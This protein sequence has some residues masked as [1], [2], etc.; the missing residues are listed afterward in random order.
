[1]FQ[2]IQRPKLADTAALYANKE[3]PSSPEDIYVTKTKITAA[4]KNSWD[5]KD[6]RNINTNQTVKILKK[7]RTNTDEQIQR[8]ASPRENSNDSHQ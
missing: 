7:V 2:R 4:Y 3:T 5:Q 1:M 8:Y 6:E